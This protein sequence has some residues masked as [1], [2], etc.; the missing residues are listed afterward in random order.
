MVVLV[1]RQWFSKVN[2][3]ARAEANVEIAIELGAVFEPIT[4]AAA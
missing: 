1:R 4:F 2:S 3:L